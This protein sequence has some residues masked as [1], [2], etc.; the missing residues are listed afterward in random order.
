[1]KAHIITRRPLILDDPSLC[2][3]ALSLFSEQSFDDVPQKQRDLNRRI[4]A[5]VLTKLDKNSVSL[6]AEEARV[7]YS[8]LLF[9]QIHL[10]ESKASDDADPE[11]LNQLPGISRLLSILEESFPVLSSQG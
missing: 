10:E 9:M 5:S 1:M 7:L 8:A 4:A 6:D 11:L 3:A 2:Q